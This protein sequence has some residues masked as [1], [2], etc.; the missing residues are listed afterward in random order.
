MKW[1][2]ENTPML[3]EYRFKLVIRIALFA[4]TAV[5]YLWNK[6]MIYRLIMTPLGQGIN[7][8]HVL[9]FIFMVMMIKH[10]F[11]KGMVTMALLKS[12]ER[13]YEAVEDYDKEE[14][15]S[16]VKTQNKRALLILVIWL[17]FNSIFGILYQ[18]KVLAK[19]DLIMLTVFYFL[20]DYICILFFCPFQTFIMKNK[21]CINC[22]I[23]DWGHFMMFTPM[24]WF[25]D[26]YGVSLFVVAC[27]VLLRWEIV[28]AKYPE[29]FFEKSNKKLKC[30]NCKDKTCQMKRACANAVRRRKG[31]V[32]KQ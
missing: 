8:M 30:E 1:K 22:R 28:Y 5:I 29:R 25:G 32:L 3:K 21:C 9:W 18:F 15:R 20:C 11:P 14:L 31:H 2:K 19:A 23:Y 27:V 4:V 12:E 16:F 17:L 6:D 13:G 24:L 10:L 26:F 7:F